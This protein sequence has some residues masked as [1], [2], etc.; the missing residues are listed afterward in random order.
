[1][2]RSVNVFICCSAALFLSTAAGQE[3]PAASGRAQELIEREQ[4][5]AAVEAAMTLGLSKPDS[6]A[7]ELDNILRATRDLQEIGPAAVAY[8]VN[9]IDQ[10]NPRTF[11]FCAFALGHFDGADA[12]DALT[13]A[14]ER[15]DG[16]PGDFALSRKGSWADR[17]SA[18]AIS[19]AQRLL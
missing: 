18:F 9:E 16:A 10:S 3:P 11:H 13:R 8:L 12:A 17:S 2:R 1:M 5:R 6:G 19:S 15:A 14:L 4:V 7:E